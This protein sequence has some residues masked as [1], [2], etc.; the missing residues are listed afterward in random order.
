MST[1][2]WAPAYG[3]VTP[4]KFML[5]E[6][7]VNEGLMPNAELKILRDIDNVWRAGE[8]QHE[9]DEGAGGICGGSARGVDDLVRG[10]LERAILRQCA[11][12]EDGDGGDRDRPD[13][14]SD[15]GRQVRIVFGDCDVQPEQASLR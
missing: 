11:A 8:V 14:A 15:D 12:V 5:T 13:R 2:V 3:E 10:D 4:A 6:S 9:P 7:V 1:M